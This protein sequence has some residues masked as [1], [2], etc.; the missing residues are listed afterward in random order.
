[1]D[2]H[3]G[4]NRRSRK[5]ESGI[6]PAAQRLLDARPNGIPRLRAG[7]ILLALTIPRVDTKPLAEAGLG[8]RRYRPLLTS[9]AE[10]LR[11]KA[12]LTRRLPRLKIAAGNGACAC[13]KAGCTDPVEPGSARR[14][15]HAA[16]AAR[17]GRAFLFLNAKH[18]LIANEAMWQGSVDEAS[19]HVRE[20]I[21]R[22]SRLAR[23]R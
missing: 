4:E 9:S 2:G 1:M 20:V 8:F 16:M 17:R 23:P 3:A 14:Y 12:S 22:A 21:A 7:R 13:S 19:V 18:V 5:I 15:L 11:A 10:T 6:A